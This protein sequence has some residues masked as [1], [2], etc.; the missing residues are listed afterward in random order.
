MMII[1]SSVQTSRVILVKTSL[2]KMKILNV[3]QNF[4][5]KRFFKLMQAVR[6]ECHF[7]EMLF[8]KKQT[9]K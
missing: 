4:E 9:E 1:F 3:K 2:K 8:S 6:K 5:S 7:N